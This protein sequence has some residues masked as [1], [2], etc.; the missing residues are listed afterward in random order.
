LPYESENSGDLVILIATGG[1]R[2]L[3]SLDR[4]IPVSLSD[5]VAKAMQVDPNDRHA[6]AR[7]MQAALLEA[8]REIDLHEIETTGAFGAARSSRP[9]P[10]SAGQRARAAA[11]THDTPAAIVAP[12]LAPVGRRRVLVVASSV[13]LLVAV[14]VGVAS[15]WPRLRPD[16]PPATAAL[17]GT[18]EPADDPHTEPTTVEVRLLGMPREGELRV[19]GAISR[20]P[21]VLPR[22]GEPH[23][24][25]VSHPL[26]T[27]WSVTHVADG[28]G[29][30]H[31][32]IAPTPV[33]EAAGEGAIE[34]EEPPRRRG[35]GTMRRGSM[36]M[37]APADMP[38]E[39]AAPSTF[40]ELDY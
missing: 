33:A 30:Y 25:E 15:A 24:I 10:P 2:E 22:D 16:P 26:M 37:D 34:L 13:G 36:D 5:V 9:P 29:E 11:I 40:R 21:I 1:A 6:T 20:L 32:R 17:P 23:V 3:H 19:D 12:T 14:G 27:P 38:A 39:E 31:V 18:A 35:R 4:T 8:A 7:D 28:P